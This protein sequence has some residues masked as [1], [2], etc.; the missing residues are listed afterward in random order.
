[1]G[2]ETTVLTTDTSGQLPTSEVLEGVQVQRVPAWPTNKDYFYAP[3]LYRCITQG[4]W[5]LVHCQGFH[6]LVAPMAMFAAWRA[7]IPY[8]VTFHS[9]GD[10]SALRKKLRGVQQ[11]ALRPL[12]AQAQ[13]LIGPSRWEVD[14]YQE[15]LHFSREQF[16]VVPN[17][18]HHLSVKTGALARKKSDKLIVSVGRLERYKGHHRVIAALPEVQKHIPEVRLRIVGVGP[19]ES[20]LRSLAER[21]GVAE[22]V[23]I[24]A[25]PPGDSD[26]MATVVGQ[27]DLVTLLS[28]HEAQGIAVL[29]ALSLK[30]PVLVADTCAL[31]EFVESNLARAVPLESSSEEVAM[32]IVRQLRDPLIPA[33][34]KLPTW[35]ECAASLYSL[36]QTI[37]GSHPVAA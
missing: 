27:A 4:H 24:G 14:Y 33:N 35:D 32:A 20:E 17:G 25:I 22:R 12:L 15:H 1:M 29:E 18:A 11:M 31:S 6:T 8:V 21:L 2:A 16:T 30:R 23:E 10:T 26:G 28:E 36:Y 5:D 3:A 7:G 34:V 19:Y 37:A 13:R 9:G